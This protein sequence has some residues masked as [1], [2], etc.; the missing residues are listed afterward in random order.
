MAKRLLIALFAVSA[1]FCAWSTEPADP[2]YERVAG[3]VG[4]PTELLY[5]MALV[6]SGRK[7][8]DDVTPWPW[9]LNVAG[10]GRYYESREAMFADLMAAL[11]RGQLSVDVG[12]MQVNWYWQ[13]TRLQ[14]PWRITDPAVNLKIGA[15][16]L[17]DHFERSG[18]WWTAV[19]LYH[20]PA[21]HDQ[22]SLD[23]AEG[24]RQRVRAQLSPDH[25]ERVNQYAF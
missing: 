18:D 12:Q 21:T 10:Q 20:R 14:S 6:E 25:I 3:Y 19:G 17:R 8:G 13:Y 9:T 7:V 11:Q 24:Y 1:V 15:Q 4:V 23:L 16:I 2:V 5:A 22:V